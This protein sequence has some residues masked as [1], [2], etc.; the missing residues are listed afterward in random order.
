MHTPGAVVPGGVGSSGVVTAK[1]GPG[2]CVSF[3]NVSTGAPSIPVGTTWKP[4]C[5][6]SSPLLNNLVLLKFYFVLYYQQLE[7]V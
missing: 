6:S 5:C 7:L 2:A 1:H 4:S 3:A